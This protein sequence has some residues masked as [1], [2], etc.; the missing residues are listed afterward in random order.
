MNCD[1]CNKPI[2]DREHLAP[3]RGDLVCAACDAAYEKWVDHQEIET[4]ARRG[5]LIHTVAV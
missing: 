3:L 4:L 5:E 1:W 2:G